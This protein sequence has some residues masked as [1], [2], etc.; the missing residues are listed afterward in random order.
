M[1]NWYSAI[2]ERQRVHKRQFAC[3]GLITFSGTI[4]SVFTLEIRMLE[5]V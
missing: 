2:E 3:L 1:F 4:V 5:A